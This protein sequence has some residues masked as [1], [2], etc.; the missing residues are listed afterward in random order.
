MASFDVEASNRLRKPC[1]DLGPDQER[2]RL[3]LAHRVMRA[4]LQNP[5][6]S[7][8]R[9]ATGVV[10]VVGGSID[11]K[12]VVMAAV[13]DVNGYAVDVLRRA[14]AMQLSIEQT[15]RMP[16][17]CTRDELYEARRAITPYDAVDVNVRGHG[18]KKRAVV[19][20][21]LADLVGEQVRLAQEQG[22]FTPPKEHEQDPRVGMHG[23]HAVVVGR[24]HPLRCV[25]WGLAWWLTRCGE[26]GVLEG[27]S[28]FFV[29]LWHPLS[30]D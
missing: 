4:I 14:R 20:V 5:E 17:R 2:E 18:S 9:A 28:P 23:H 12:G 26:Q 3:A 27:H 8:R 13:A 21:S 25:S 1:F 24:C 29:L 30:D 22:V 7:F 11:N 15:L 10:S 19:A 16:R 6:V